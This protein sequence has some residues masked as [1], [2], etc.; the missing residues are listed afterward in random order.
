MV[1]SGGSVDRCVLV[2]AGHLTDQLLEQ[3]LNSLEDIRADLNAS[4]LFGM[5]LKAAI[6]GWAVGSTVHGPRCRCC[7]SA[8]AVVVPF[9]L[10]GAGF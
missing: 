10:G 8:R 1:C 7:L 2:L 3:N 6:P 9:Q 5:G 4:I